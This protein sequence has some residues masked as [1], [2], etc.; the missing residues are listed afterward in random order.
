[1]KKK[2]VALALALAG[3]MSVSACQTPQQQTGTLAGGAIGAGTRRVARIRDFG[4]QC[5]RRHRRRRDRCRHRRADWQRRDTSATTLRA[6]GFRPIRQ[7]R[8]SSLASLVKP[9]R[10]PPPR[11]GAGPASYS[12]VI[13]RL[14][15][16]ESR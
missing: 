6:M 1:M 3:A 7:P 10:Q 14:A 16:M 5:R 12:D 11:A 8:V 4:R 15:A 9:R 2:M 13:V